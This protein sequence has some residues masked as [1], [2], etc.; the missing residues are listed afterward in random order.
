[1][2]RRAAKNVT[3]NGLT[4]YNVRA[5]STYGRKIVVDARH[6]EDMKVEVFF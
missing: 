2:L 6:S 5:E 1:M 3:E 4:M